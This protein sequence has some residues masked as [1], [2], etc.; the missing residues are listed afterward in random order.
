MRRTLHML[1]TFTKL[2]TPILPRLPS[3]RLQP[4]LASSTSRPSFLSS[5]TPKTSRQPQA[6]SRREP[7]KAVTKPPPRQSTNPQEPTPKSRKLKKL[8]PALPLPS[9][10]ETAQD[11]PPTNQCAY[12]SP[13]TYHLLQNRFLI[14]LFIIV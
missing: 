5:D 3:G 6:K 1:A 9:K 12:I 11:I 8:S 14:A 10:T 4:H 13:T 7:R 2:V